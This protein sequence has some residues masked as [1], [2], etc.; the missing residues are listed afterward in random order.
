MLKHDLAPS[1]RDNHFN[2]LQ[3]AHEADPL[4]AE[5]SGIQQIYD[6]HINGYAGRFSQS[7][8]EQ[9][10]TMPEVA[11]I[12]QDQIVHTMDVQRSAP[13]VGLS[14]CISGRYRVV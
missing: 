1:L 9:L 2:F 6:G 4:L 13:W 11:Y 14:N 3:A 10:R 5:E 8:V 12:E 7:V